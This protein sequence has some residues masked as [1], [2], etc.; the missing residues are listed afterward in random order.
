MTTPENTRRRLRPSTVVLIAAIVVAVLTGASGIAPAF[1][2]FHDSSREI[3]PEFFGIP[4]ALRA[5]FYTSTVVAIVAAGWLLSLRVQNWERGQP[6]K[7]T[8]TSANRTRRVADLRRGLTMQTL[9]RDPA[10]GLMHSL[11]Y[12]PFPSCSR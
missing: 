10:A 4:H 3:R 12:F 9:L 5:L 1:E 6:D 11:I 2:V 8:T 7:R